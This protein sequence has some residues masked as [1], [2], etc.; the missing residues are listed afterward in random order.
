MLRR[1]IGFHQIGMASSPRRPR[2]AAGATPRP[3]AT[4]STSARASARRRTT[5]TEGTPVFS[6]RNYSLLGIALALVVIGYVIMRA[7]NAV[8][9]PISLYVS[10][11]LLLAGYL[12]VIY[13]ILWR[14]KAAP[15]E[16]DAATA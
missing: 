7:E 9:G 1:A 12:G 8:D 14:P 3:A 4:A 2:T 10:P 13:A 15:A 5:T 11:I 6:R 16:S